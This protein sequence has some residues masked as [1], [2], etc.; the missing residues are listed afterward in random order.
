MNRPFR[1]VL[2][3][4]ASSENGPSH[5]THLSRRPSMKTPTRPAQESRHKP[6]ADSG[7]CLLAAVAEIVGLYV[8]P[9]SSQTYQPF[10]YFL[11]Q[12]GIDWYHLLFY[13]FLTIFL[14]WLPMYTLGEIRD[15]EMSF[16]IDTINPKK[17]WNYII[18]EERGTKINNE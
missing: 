9:A 16:I 4:A 3:I 5:T 8:V 13:P 18:D 7:I 1:S 17:L 6:W 12:Y 11:G 15:K 2:W 14:F 10:L